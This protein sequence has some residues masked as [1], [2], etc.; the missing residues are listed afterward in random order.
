[1]YKPKGYIGG[2]PYMAKYKNGSD[3]YEH[4]IRKRTLQVS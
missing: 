1:M 3:L 4:R 2:N